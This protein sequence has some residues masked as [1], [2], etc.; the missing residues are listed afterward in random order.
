MLRINPTEA[1]IQLI[2]ATRTITIAPGEAEDVPGDFAKELRAN[3]A[4]RAFLDQL[5][6]VDE[7][8]KVA[9]ALD[10]AKAKRLAIE[11]AAKAKGKGKTDEKDDEAKDA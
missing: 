1:T 3:P 8:A 7:G 2:T 11:A 5:I 4:G 9:D 6:P 10:A